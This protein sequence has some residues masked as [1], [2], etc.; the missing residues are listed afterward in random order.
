[1]SLIDGET[2]IGTTPIVYRTSIE[3]INTYVTFY[4]S[5]G[6]NYTHVCSIRCPLWIIA[7]LLWILIQLISGNLLCKEY[8]CILPE[9]ILSKNNFVTECK[10]RIH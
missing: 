6:L 8:I 3:V 4:I 2:E 10:I 5:N 9:S 7:G 1:M